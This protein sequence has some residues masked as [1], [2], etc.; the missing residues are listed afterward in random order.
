MQERPPSGR[1][2]SLD[3]VPRMTVEGEL[4][5][6]K[7]LPPIQLPSADEEVAMRRAERQR[8]GVL[9]AK[10]SPPRPFLLH[11]GLTSRTHDIAHFQEN[12]PS[13]YPHFYIDRWVAPH[14]AS[15]CSLIWGF[16]SMYCTH[17]FT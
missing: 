17:L 1:L 5:R 2:A 4:T 13:D 6:Y 16:V 3:G 8:E 10:P 7:T 12:F 15:F 9:W 11:L 14:F